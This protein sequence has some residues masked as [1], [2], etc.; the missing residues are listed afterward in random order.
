[1][2]KL[3]K[4]LLISEKR[5]LGYSISSIEELKKIDN[6]NKDVIP[7]ILRHLSRITEVNQ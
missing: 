2:E 3:N 5:D 1:M 7:I 6:K 4:E